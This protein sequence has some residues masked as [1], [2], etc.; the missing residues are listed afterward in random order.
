MFRIVILVVLVILFYGLFRRQKK[1][2]TEK[3]YNKLLKKALGDQ[4]LALRLIEHER[5]KNPDADRR[6]L[7]ENALY[8]WERE[9]R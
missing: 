7:I 5:E 8:Q 2:E 6:Q 1:A 4:E 3:L 9:G